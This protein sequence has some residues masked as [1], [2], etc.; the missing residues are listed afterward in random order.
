M[1]TIKDV[2]LISIQETRDLVEKAYEA[3][4]GFEKLDQEKTNNVVNSLARVLYE[5]SE[6]LAKLA[7]ETTKFGRWEDKKTK[8]ILASEI[9]NDYMKNIK[10]RGIINEDKD[11]KIYEVAVPMGV[12]AGII[13]TTNPTSTVIFKTLISLKAG[14]AIVFS[15][16]PR[17]LECILKTV[18]IIKSELKRLGIDDNLVGCI[19]NPTMV[20]T[21]ELMKHDKVA[22]ILATGGSAMVKSAYSSGKPAL[23]VGPGNVPAYIDKTANVEKAVA[24][25]L[26][27]KTFDN[28]TICA[29]EQSIIA[30]SAVSDLV[31]KE[32]I[33]QGAYI[34]NEEE[35]KKVEKILV[36]P[37]GAFNPNI[38]GLDGKTLADMAGIKV[39]DYT[40]VLIAPETGVGKKFPFSIEKLTCILAFYEAKNLDDAKYIALSLI[41]FAG[42]GHSCAIHANDKERILNYSS[43]MPVSRVLV[44]TPTSQ[45]AVGYATSLTPSFTL[46]CGSYGGNATSDNISVLHLFNRKRIAYGVNDISKIKD[47]SKG[48]SNNSMNNIYNDEFINKI[49]IEVKKALNNKI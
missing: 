37:T 30:H 9:L 7:C 10:T 28:G 26:C 15:P 45:G 34:L 21:S 46:G 22:I 32:C 23:G 40:R 25:I 44:N 13:P 14:N 31:K 27:S 47:F 35:K 4:K 24:D 36:G 5:N 19:S 8:N 18:E 3:Q 39:P 16:H 12:V 20:A 29:S 41:R 33:R 43:V 2:D 17:A 1:E 6:Y 42:M 48:S 38:V 11:N 49:I